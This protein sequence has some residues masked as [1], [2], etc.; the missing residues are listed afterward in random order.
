MNTKVQIKKFIP[1]VVI[2]ALMFTS[3]YFARIIVLTYEPIAEG[4][5]GLVLLTLAYRVYYLSPDL[6][7]KE[8]TRL[9][10][11]YPGGFKY[12]GVGVFWAVINYWAVIQILDMFRYV[13][14]FVAK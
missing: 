14:Q 6:N 13:W 11:E 5:L 7:I 3:L 8:P 4:I 2:T 1:V 9:L 12:L 10:F